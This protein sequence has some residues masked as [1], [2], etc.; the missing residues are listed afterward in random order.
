MSG[1]AALGVLIFILI[2][3]IAARGEPFGPG[4]L[5]L[6]SYSPGFP[7]S[8]GEV[9]GLQ[10]VLPEEARCFVEYLDGGRAGDREAFLDLF[11]RRLEIK[12]GARR[13]FRLVVAMGDDALEWARTRGARLFPD[14]PVVFCDVHDFKEDMAAGNSHITGVVEPLGIKDSIEVGLKL[15]PHARRVF[16]VTD[17]ST[18]GRFNR[19]IL[20]GLG[21]S[22]E[23]PA[24][25]V[26]L[27]SGKGLLLNEL[28]T[29]LQEVPSDSIV[30]YSGFL[31]DRDGETLT[32]RQVMPIVSRNTPVPVYAHEGIYVGLGAVGGRVNNGYDHGQTV[33]RVVNRILGGESASQIPVHKS[34]SPRY[35]F[36]FRE[37]KRW[38]I[39]LSALPADSMVINREQSF[40]ERYRGV[41][42]E[43]LVFLVLQSLVLVY[44]L[45]NISRRR[46]AQDAMVESEERLRTIYEAANRVA[47]VMTDSQEPDARITE[48]SL[49]AERMFEYTRDEMV[50]RAVSV[51]YPLETE[52]DPAG[53]R[54]ILCEDDVGVGVE[55][56]LVRKS[57]HR[58]AA[59]TSVYP[60]HDEKTQQTG[61]LF[62]TFDISELKQAQD[63]VRESEEKYRLVVENANEAIFIA[64]DG[65]IKFPNPMTSFLLG[66]TAEELAAIAFGEHVHP[67]DRAMVIQRHQSRM[68]GEEVVQ[69]YTFRIVN[70]DEQLLWM[71]INAVL[72]QWEG[73]SATLCFLRD[74]TSEKN[75]EAQLLRA[76]KMQAV[77]T[78]AGGIAHDFNNLLQ[79]ILGYAD[80]LL[81]KMQDGEKASHG[82][83]QIVRAAQRGSDLTRQL[84]TFS[85]KIESKMESVDLNQV[86]ERSYG[87]LERTLPRM[88]T[89]DL[90]LQEG[91]S[92]VH[93]DPGQI[94]QVLMNLALNARDAMPNGG[95][96]TIETRNMFLGEDYC[97]LH[98][99]VRPGEYVLLTV[100]DAGHGMD[101]ETLQR[102][103]DPFFTTK[104][105][106][107]GTGLGLAMVYG[108]VKNHS[109]HIT[110][111]SELE[112]GARFEIY[113]PVSE[114]K[115]EKEPTVPSSP[116]VG[117]HETILLVDDDEAIRELGADILGQYGYN[118]LT[119]LDGESALEIYASRKGEIDLILLDMS[120]PGMGG[121]QCLIHLVEMNPDVRVVIASG[122]SSHGP[123]KDA[124]LL[125]ARSVV[126]KP[127]NIS[128]ILGV[129]R[130][131]LE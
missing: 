110:C 123:V 30:Y 35:M 49:G 33:G 104:E 55:S 29:K 78:L 108:I 63:A 131:A 121:R 5:V 93:A 32:P 16:L 31:L 47:F 72:V 117:G 120:M 130:K 54:P 96:L 36:D 91:L 95:K 9:S 115:D 7:H 84:L 20:E 8:D 44:L 105:T 38:S 79:A 1:L 116:K 66:Y 56:C 10:S 103:F 82:L 57:G 14:L 83:R 70:K 53:R 18:T 27:D 92:Q 62:I 41:V 98:P 50:G 86:L 19:K 21:E 17:S 73:R 28:L 42:W 60:V 51:L 71:H 61:G 65:V 69:N 52:T 88:I 111:H 99:E 122:Y 3:S 107:K 22:G 4:V 101:K 34:G 67:E 43:V 128:E 87:I 126:N 68:A 114:G 127:Y 85:R 102:I 6:S 89:M 45:A 12:Y 48:F 58:F 76:Q 37:L 13:P 94:E 129:I 81:H 26:F 77:G 118:V 125:G 124:V 2:G 119:A 23:I 39:P 15:H 64:Q 106:G 46:K 24:E 25:L 112:R 113:L 97:G 90:R 11:S 40:Y 74:I 59:L 75:L 109:G 80:M 100:A